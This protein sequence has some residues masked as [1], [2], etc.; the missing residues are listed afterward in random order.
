MSFTG[1]AVIRN[2]HNCPENLKPS[3]KFRRRWKVHNL[4]EFKGEKVG[5]NGLGSVGAGYGLVAGPCEHDNER[6]V[7]TE[8]GNF[9][10]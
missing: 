4:I 9:L 1:H 6:T 10:D 5:K 7:A 3:V 2:I 8:T